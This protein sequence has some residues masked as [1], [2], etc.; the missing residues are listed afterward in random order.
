[1]VH[2]LSSTVLDR[3]EDVRLARPAVA[4]LDAPEGMMFDEVLVG[5]VGSQAVDRYTSDPSPLADPSPLCGIYAINT[6]STESYHETIASTT[7]SNRSFVSS[8]QL[9]F[10]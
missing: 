1:M 9:A 7:R 10:A 8:T 4:V 3:F 5:G 6:D 2:R